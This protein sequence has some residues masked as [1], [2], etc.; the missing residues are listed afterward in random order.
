MLFGDF[1]G[2]FIQS[3]SA[4]AEAWADNDSPY[5]MVHSDP[6]TDLDLKVLTFQESR[7]AAAFRAGWAVAARALKASSTA[8]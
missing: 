3:C 7:A 1:L 2:R 4:D 5:L 6:Q 8:N